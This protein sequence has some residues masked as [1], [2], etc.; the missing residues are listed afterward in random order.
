MN[1]LED[2][3]LLTYEQAARYLNFGSSQDVKR[4]VYAKRLK[5]YRYGHK[6]VR[7]HRDDLDKFKRSTATVVIH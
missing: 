4:L 1:S 5:A 6:T 2:S 3:S 7:I